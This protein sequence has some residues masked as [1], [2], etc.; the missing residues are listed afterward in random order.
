MIIS[1]ACEYAI[2]ATLYISSE[3]ERPY[4]PIREIAGK[5]DISFH[6]LTKILQILTQNQLLQSYKGP[7]GGVALARPAAEITAMQIVQA[8]DGPDLFNNCL[9]GLAECHDD[10]PCPL[11]PSWAGI[12]A[13]IQTLFE[14]T[15]LDQMAEQI[16]NH[17]SFL[18]SGT[19]D[20]A[21]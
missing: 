17:G 16:K 20:Q 7:H 19:R 13:Q 1:K 15:K 11:H 6:F 3:S 4:V 5:L 10:H 21:Q 8:I 12:R 9:L 18:S 2:R 14:G